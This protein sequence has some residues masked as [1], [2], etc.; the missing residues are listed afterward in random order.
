[1]SRAPEPLAGRA[2]E[3][4]TPCALCGRRGVSLTRHHLIPRSRHRHRA[5][6]RQFS[7]AQCVTAILMICKPCHKQIHALFS[8]KELA[9]YYHTRERLA[10]H[11]DMQRFITW[12]AR[13]PPGF[14]PL[15]RRRA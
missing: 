6:R 5:T 15:T 1:M 11:A 3:A 10:A 9:R 8:E 4:D 13:K 7:Y 12:I 2:D 14:I